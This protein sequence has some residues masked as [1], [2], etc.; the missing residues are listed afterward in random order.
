[1]DLQGLAI[2]AARAFAVYVLIL[3][4]IRTLGKRTVGNF[5]P[6]SICSSP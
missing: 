2:T 3:L 5:S 1:M 6:R 4:V